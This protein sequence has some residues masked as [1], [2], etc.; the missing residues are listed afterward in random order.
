MGDKGTYTLIENI[1]LGVPI[2]VSQEIKPIYILTYN[3]FI[4][5]CLETI[6]TI[7]KTLDEDRVEVGR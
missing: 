3:L 4:E 5:E 7:K 6:I 2:P 1:E